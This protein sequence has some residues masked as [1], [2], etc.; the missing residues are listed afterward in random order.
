MRYV[1][2]GYLRTRLR[3]VEQHVMAVLDSPEVLPR[4]SHQVGSC[5]ACAS[6]VP[7]PVVGLPGF[8]HLPA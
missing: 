7:P 1:L 4:L 6:P 3:K 8:W 5:P 2:R